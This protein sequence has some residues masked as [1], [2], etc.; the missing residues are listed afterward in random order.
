MMLLALNGNNTSF[1]FRPSQLSFVQNLDTIRVPN[2]DITMFPLL[3]EG[4]LEGEIRRSGLLYVDEALD[5]TRPFEVVLDMAPNP[6]IAASQYVVTPP[7][8]VAAAESQDPGAAGSG[9]AA[10][11]GGALAASGTDVAL[12]A[13]DSTRGGG[14]GI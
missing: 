13:A 2:E 6:G 14:A 4:K 1:F 10:D 9:G 8:M 12:A 11:A 5:I 3:T 7:A